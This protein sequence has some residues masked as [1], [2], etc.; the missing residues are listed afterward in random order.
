MKKIAALALM[1]AFMLACNTADQKTTNENEKFVQDSLANE[2]KKL[3]L[4]DSSNVTTLEWVDSTRQDL[5]RVKEGQVVEVSYRF[6]NT[7]DKP[8]VITNVS[9]SCGCTIPETPQKP[10]APGEEGVIRAKFDSKGRS[11]HNTKDVYV[12]ANTRPASYQLAF[13]V[14][15][16]N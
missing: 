1:S 3:I 14:E 9:A 8:L 13:S 6:R 4:E 15:V 11:G 10:F 12:T 16:T 7:G 2:K 5:G